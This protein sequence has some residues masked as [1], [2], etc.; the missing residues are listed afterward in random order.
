MLIWITVICEAFFSQID[1]VDPQR[2]IT[3]HPN[4][5]MWGKDVMEISGEKYCS[6]GHFPT[7]GGLLRLKLGQC[8]AKSAIVKVQAKPC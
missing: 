8:P 2:V 4:F 5:T 3:N 6:L 7:I 1:V